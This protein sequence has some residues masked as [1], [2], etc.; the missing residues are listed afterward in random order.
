MSLQDLILQADDLP[1]PTPVPTPE[2][3]AVDGQVCVARS[4]TEGLAGFWAWFTEKAR[5]GDPLGPWA[6]A[7]FACDGE[8][9]PLFD[10]TEET[11]RALA[12]KAGCVVSRIFHAVDELNYLTEASRE[13]FRKNW[14]AGASAATCNLPGSAGSP[15]AE[16]CTNDTPT[17]AS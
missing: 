8:G 1:R 16:N 11:A 2:W 14:T 9:K 13:H 15:A 5:D 4:D 12:G 6:V 7:W 17:P 10:R 3:P